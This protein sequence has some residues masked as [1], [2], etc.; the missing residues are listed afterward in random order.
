MMGEQARTEPLF[1][2]FRLEDQVPEHHLLRRLDRYVDFSFVRE[3]LREAYSPLG[4]P[5]ID[6]EILLRILLVGYLYGIT[7]ERRLVEEVRM[8]LAYRWFTRLGFEQEIPDHSTFSKNRHGRFRESRIFLEVFEE[9]V[10]RCLA[11]GLVEGRQ[12]TVDGTVVA[13]NASPQKGVKRDQ[14]EEVAKVS[15]TV[16]EY[17]AEVAQ[18]N[19][20]A[21]S[22]D[23]PP[24]PRSVAARFVS[25][26][27][28]DACWAGKGGP[29]VPSYYDHYLMDNAHGIILGVE[30]TPARFRQET[31]AARRM[32]QQVKERFG[33][34][35]ESLGAD[36]GYGSG[37]FLAWLLERNIQ[38]HIPVIDRRHQTHQRF[39]RDQFLYDPVENVFRC[40]QGQLLRY[41]SMSRQNQ[42]YIYRTTALQCRGC[43]LKKRCTPAPFRKILVH[44]YEPARQVARDL[45]QTPAYAQSRRDR[46][47]IEAL[48]SELK[49]RL[50][51]RRV[52]LR[53]LWNVAEQFHLAA[54]AQN[55][56]RLVKFL[57]QREPVPA[58]CST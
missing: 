56:K 45:A 43:P 35:P 53:R 32:L 12:L 34:C 6:P 50:G 40:P 4:R 46:N 37:E 19:P 33:I 11:L 21:E 20:V 38:P 42:G 17:L 15:R 51:L 55:L 25:R 47:K 1:Y 5:S 16:R 7:S 8:H 36:K 28:P 14:L 18:E 52:R 58:V 10:R 30:A 27:D 3:R 49:L 44:W 9:I 54:T 2:Y 29:A 23:R 24:A 48:F 39:T 13:A 26:S 57:A 22:D 41:H 31:L